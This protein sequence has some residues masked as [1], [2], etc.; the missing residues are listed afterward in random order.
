[1]RKIGIIFV[2]DFLGHAISAAEITAICDG[3]A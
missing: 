3:D 1:M 2:E